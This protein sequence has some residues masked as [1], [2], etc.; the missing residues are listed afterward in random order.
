MTR[1]TE[2]LRWPWLVVAFLLGVAGFCTTATVLGLGVEESDGTSISLRDESAR[3]SRYFG[4]RG[5]S[6][7][8][9]GLLG[10]K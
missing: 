9:G 10:G 8:G 1:T 2:R 7:R 3:Q 4:V 6:H 5:H